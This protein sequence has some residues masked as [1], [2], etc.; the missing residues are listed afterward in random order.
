MAQTIERMNS[1]EAEKR[2]ASTGPATATVDERILARRVREAKKAKATA[3]NEADRVSTDIGSPLVAPD[4]TLRIVPNLGRTVTVVG[5]VTNVDVNDGPH[6]KNVRGE[7]GKA[8]NHWYTKTVAKDPLMR[9]TDN[10]HAADKRNFLT[11]HTNATSKGVINPKKP[12]VVDP[13]KLSKHIKKVAK[14]LGADLVGIAAANPAFM[15]ASGSATSRTARRT[16]R[17]SR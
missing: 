2:E 12:D 4:G 17:T 13:K 3:V 5:M 11:T 15:Y 7:L 14:H 1:T 16:T 6:P 10:T 8:M 9:A